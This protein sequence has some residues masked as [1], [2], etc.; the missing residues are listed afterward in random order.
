MVKKLNPGPIGSDVDDFVTAAL[1]S[2][3]REYGQQRVYTAA[4]HEKFEYGVEIP[5]HAL[6]LRFLTSSNIWPLQRVTQSCGRTRTCKS[7]FMFELERWF[8]EADGVV[9]HY[10]TENKTSASLLG[11]IIPPRFLEKGK[12]S[13]RYTL[14]RTGTINEWQQ[15]MGQDFET[16]D[17]LYKAKGRKSFPIFWGVDPLMGS[18]S[19]DMAA[20]IHKLG[21]AP[22]RTFSDAPRMIW[23]FLRD[24]TT[25]TINIPITVHFSHHE[26]VATGKR[27]G[28]DKAGGTGIEFLATIDLHF[29]LGQLQAAEEAYVARSPEFTQMVR[30]SNVPIQGK[31]INILCKKNSNAPDVDKRIY[32]P[33]RWTW[34]HDPT[35]PNGWRQISWW[36]WET[37]AADLM[38]HQERAL[39]DVIDVRRN[40][41]TVGANQKYM[42]D[43]LGIDKGVPADEFGKLVT[44]DPE[45]LAEIQAALHIQQQVVFNADLLKVEKLAKKGKKPAAT[46]KP[47]ARAG[48]KKKVAAKK[49]AKKPVVTK[50][51]AEPKAPL[52]SPPSPRK[53]TTDGRVP[54]PDSLKPEGELSSE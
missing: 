29:R 16:L 22:G 52:P 54:A 18:D 9:G 32:V 37:A 33:F 30:G 11:S 19:A 44:S 14:R 41:S 51:M 48:T 50:P 20:A 2:A 6:A 21:E 3:Q 42:S 28:V 17:S 24:L 35:L 31:H 40:S 12:L 15:M 23:Q 27:G 46:T 25:K 39:R 10:D 53:L 38:F 1:E 49:P 5:P 47:P 36:D 43:K 7:A 8:L 26:R 34:L 13:Q 45:L 4:E